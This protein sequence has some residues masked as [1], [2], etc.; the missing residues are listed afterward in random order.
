[1][2]RKKFDP[3][4]AFPEEIVEDIRNGLPEPILFSGP[5]Y[6]DTGEE[7]AVLTEHEQAID[8]I[9]SGEDTRDFTDAELIARAIKRMTGLPADAESGPPIAAQANMRGH[10]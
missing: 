5:I 3:A 1:M 8:R 10:S 6:I 4:E 9:A 7:S 2:W